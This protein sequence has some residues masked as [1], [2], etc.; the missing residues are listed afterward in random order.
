MLWLGSWCLASPPAPASYS[1]SLDLRVRCLAKPPF[2]TAQLCCPLWA[3]L[4]PRAPHCASVTGLVTPWKAGFLGFPPWP[5]HKFLEGK[6]CASFFSVVPGVG[7]IMRAQNNVNEQINYIV[8]SLWTLFPTVFSKSCPT[9]LW[10]P[11]GYTN[12]GIPIT[13]Q[14]L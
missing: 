1:S 6:K 2:W 3:P 5:D 4:V 8:K 13:E 7:H 12:V 11:L 10:G 14:S 9:V